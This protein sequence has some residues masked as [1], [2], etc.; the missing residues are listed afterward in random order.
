MAMESAVSLYGR[1]FWWGACLTPPFVL[2]VEMDTARTAH[3][4]DAAL[5]KTFIEVPVY[6]LVFL[7]GAVL[8]VLAAISRVVTKRETSFLSTLGISPAAM[9]LL[10][11]YYDSQLGWP[12]LGLPPGAVVRSVAVT[13]LWVLL[14]VWFRR[15]AWPLRSLARPTVR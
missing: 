7:A 1:L 11:N 14:A 2:L 9:L 8:V 6:L 10:F 13:A 15:A 4:A 5:G 3:S 12:K